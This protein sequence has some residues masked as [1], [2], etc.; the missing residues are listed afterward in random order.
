[1]V[2]FDTQ[3]AHILAGKSERPLENI[4]KFRES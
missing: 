2:S 4:S 3:A 1:M